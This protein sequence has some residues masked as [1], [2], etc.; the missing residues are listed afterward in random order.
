[1]GDHRLIIGVHNQEN[2]ELQAN[3][4]PVGA[5]ATRQGTFSTFLA[6]LTQDTF[7]TGRSGCRAKITDCP[8]NPVNAGFSGI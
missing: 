1:V 4:P 5:L 6:P 8:S 2:L 7:K 3:S